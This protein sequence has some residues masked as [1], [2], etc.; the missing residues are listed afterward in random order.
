MKSESKYLSKKQAQ[1]LICI[2]EQNWLHARHIESG[3]LTFTYLYFG[4]VAGILTY[5]GSTEQDLLVPS[6]RVLI[7]FLLLFS[8]LG[9]VVSL[10]LAA[11]FKNH[12]K[13]I[14][15]ILDEKASDL[16][17][18]MGLPLDVGVW[19]YLKVRWVFVFSYLFTMILWL[20]LLILS[21]I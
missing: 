19:K 9:L 10:K 5:L 3:R 13:K 7:A 16:K 12:I 17:D 4:F 1:V 18:Y 11:E 8:I 21:F 6:Y 15:N 20:L 14:Q 2:I